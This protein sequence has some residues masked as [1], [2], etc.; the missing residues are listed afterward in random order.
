MQRDPLDREL[1]FTYTVDPVSQDTETTIVDASD[2]TTVQTYQNGKLIKVV[3]AQGTPDE[4]TERYYYDLKTLGVTTYRNGAGRSWSYAY[5]ERGNR[6]YERAP[7]GDEKRWSYNALNEVLIVTDAR[8]VKTTNIYDALGNLQS[9]ETPVSVGGPIAKTVLHYDDPAHPGDITS[10]TDAD[11]KTTTMTR[12]ARGDLVSTANGEGD[13]TTFAYN[14]IGWLQSSVSP[15]GNQPGAVS[16]DFRASYARDAMG[17]VLGVADPLGRTTGAT[18]DGEG[19][20][21]TSTNSS[22]QMT[23]Y[24]YDE[25]G[26]LKRVE[27]PQNPDLTYTYWPNGKLKT[28]IDGNQKET[29]YAYDAADRLSVRTDPLQRKTS[30]QYDG[31]NHVTVMTDAINRTTTYGYDRTG[32]VKTVDYSDAFTPDES[33]VY[34]RAGNRLSAIDGSGTSR[35][36]YDNLGRV[37]EQRTGH[38]NVVGYTYSPAGRLNQI[39][40]PGS[41]RHVDYGYD[42]A[43]RM[44]MAHDWTG[45]DYVFGYDP[46]GSLSSTTYPNGVIGSRAINR[47]GEATS[48]SYNHGAQSVASFG[49]TYDSA[50]LVS[51]VTSTNTPGPIGQTLAYDALQRV[52]G[53]NDGSGLQ[54]FGF[55]GA[56]NLTGRGAGS[57]ST[58]DDARQLEAMTVAGGD[59]TIF[60]HN[61][62]G[63]RISSQHGPDLSTFDYDQAGRLKTFTEDGGTSSYVYDSDGVRQSKSHGGQSE[64]MTWSTGASPELLSDSVY[65][66][67]Y[68]P[69]GV[70][71]TQIS[72]FGVR[73]YLHED[74]L[75]SVRGITNQVGSLVGAASYDTYG[76]V[77]ATGARSAF[78]YAGEYTDE[79]SGL[80]YLRARYYDPATG[81]FLTRD[82]IEDVTGDPY[83]YANGNPLM[84]TDPTGLMSWA[85]GL[86]WVSA[87]AAVLALTPL[88]PVALGTIAV[89]AGVSS[90]YL[91]YRDGDTFGAA[92]Q[93]GSEILGGAV[94][95]G[96]KVAGTAAGASG[97]GVLGLA[98]VPQPV[99]EQCPA[100]Q[101]PAPP[102]APTMPGLDYT[103]FT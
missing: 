67:V 30:Y 43:G 61:A 2:H 6:T 1:N 71:L 28:E 93:I 40:Y 22:N 86:G 16:A 38:G 41:S 34:D 24:H 64:W 59:T 3:T 25:A 78:G 89:V 92:C 77:A 18:Y 69:G 7:T 90:A 84:N 19:N 62:V 47:S 46:D 74:Q 91:S 4:H 20:L 11:L 26:Q 98:V 21:L 70:P 15:R 55:D 65:S 76:S 50:G 100:Y 54:G 102:P 5:D 79:E 13:S 8:G 81:Q 45:G 87:G 95:I 85:E 27:R 83:G 97:C 35:A 44:S 88:A 37:V 94:A 33:F 14:S 80:Q 42:G 57:S 17:R 23:S 48:I 53:V 63:E 82:P 29:K 36:V 12:D 10:V 9:S 99:P 31:A 73:S 39:A 49:R 68:G 58:F 32:R 96:N 103:P 60:Q 101:A 56:G 75:G 72:E 66:Y 51:S 52:A